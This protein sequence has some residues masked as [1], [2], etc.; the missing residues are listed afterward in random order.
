MRGR[1]FLPL[2]LLL[3]LLARPSFSQSS[4]CFLLYLSCFS[5]GSVSGEGWEMNV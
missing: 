1:A 2:F 3:S 4:R 5:A